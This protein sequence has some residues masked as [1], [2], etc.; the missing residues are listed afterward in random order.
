MRRG[1]R[2]APV[3][4]FGPGRPCGSFIGDAPPGVFPFVRLPTPPP[5][6]A[7]TFPT[8]RHED[9]MPARKTTP[10]PAAF[11]RR[12]ARAAGKAET[13]R[14][15]EAEK[16]AAMPVTNRHAAGIDVGCH[17]HWVCAG[18]GDAGDRAIVREFPADTRGLREAVA[19]LKERGITTVAM[20]ATGVYWVPLFEMLEAAGMEALLVDPSFTRQLRG[21]PKTDRLD[22]Q[23]ICRLHS[24]GLLRG[25]FRPAR[26]VATLRAYLRQRGQV[27]REAGQCVQR[28]QKALALMNLKLTG[29]L[30]SITGLTGQ[31]II[32]AILKGTRDPMKLAALRDRRCSASQEEIARAMEGT[33]HEEHLFCLRQAWQAWKFHQ[34]QLDDVDAMIAAQLGRMRRPDA[35]PPP[36]ARKETGRK[37]NDP[38]FDARTA[39]GL[40]AGLDLTSIEGIDETTALV[41]LSEIGADMSKWPTVKHFCS[42]LGLCPNFRKTGGKV[43]S[44]RTRPGS[45]R[46]AQALRLA[47]SG[48]HRSKGALGAYLR[49][50]K[51]RLGKASA[52]TAAAHKLARIVYL[53]LKHGKDYVRRSQEEYEAEQREKRI[54]SLK[55]R[56]RELGLEVVEKAEAEAAG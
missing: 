8:T 22:A 21:R 2:P 44:S 50:M 12:K 40:V 56:A 51:G 35:V 47:A 4:E 3:V 49:R 18:I 16:V 15:Q 27:L 31:K 9:A 10:G 46:A 42:W 41:L 28:M 52:V 17:S 11:K 19:F 23:W 26:E 38:R 29:V 24:V 7:R 5:A 20:E 34:G 43:K 30:S 39:L 13:L 53:S 37:P 33:W 45:N 1:L 48:L 55:R 14:R 32:Q 54:A 6:P 25:A 36:E